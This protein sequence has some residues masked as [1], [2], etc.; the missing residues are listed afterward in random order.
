[1]ENNDLADN[2]D[3][4]VDVESVLEIVAVEIVEVENVEVEN[5]E[6][7]NDM[8]DGLGKNVEEVDNAKVPE[9]A[10]D[11]AENN[12]FNNYCR[13]AG[14]IALGGVVG[15]VAMPLIA[16]TGLYYAGFTATGMMMDIDRFHL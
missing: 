15:Y 16:T 4:T 5:G 1:M 10:K 11:N 7:E 13:V 14:A 2:S 9:E 8:E 3:P 6:V 12:S